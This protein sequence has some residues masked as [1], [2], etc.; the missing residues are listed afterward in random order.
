MRIPLRPCCS[1][2]KCYNVLN[3]KCLS[4][5]VVGEED[6][7]ATVAR[8]DPARGGVPHGAVEVVA[9][10]LAVELTVAVLDVALDELLKVDGVLRKAKH[11]L[12]LIPRMVHVA[13]T[14]SCPI[15]ADALFLLSAFPFLFLCL[16]PGADS[17]WY[18][19]SVTI[20]GSTAG[21]LSF[22][23]ESMLFQDL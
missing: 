22:A 9:G 6:R 19:I 13:D 16:A 21:L 10:A 18:L 17:F 4:L 20:F 3:R 12:R 5:A 15:S 23:N 11:S 8:V 7:A 2:I 14:L 1:V